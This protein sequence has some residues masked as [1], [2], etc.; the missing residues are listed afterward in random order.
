MRNAVLSIFLCATPMLAE[1]V[2]ILAL[3]DSLTEGY[4]LPP[5]QGFVPQLQ[6]WLAAGEARVMGFMDRH[7]AAI[8]DF[9]VRGYDGFFNLNTPED[10]AQAERLLAQ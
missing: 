3:G 5:D 9:P 8:C 1:P 6:A 2:T 7:H 10:L 4:G